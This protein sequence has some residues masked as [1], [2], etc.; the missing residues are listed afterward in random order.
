MKKKKQETVWLV[1][2]F[3]SVIGLIFSIPMAIFQIIW[4]IIG[5]G[6]STILLIICLLVGLTVCCGCTGFIFMML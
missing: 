1:D 6:I 5:G 2:L 4:V 3:T